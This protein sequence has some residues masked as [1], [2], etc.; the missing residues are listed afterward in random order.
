MVV[1]EAPSAAAD[2][3]QYFRGGWDVLSPP[4]KRHHKQVRKAPSKARN[5]KTCIIETYLP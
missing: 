2:G 3:A 4:R 5:R 1:S